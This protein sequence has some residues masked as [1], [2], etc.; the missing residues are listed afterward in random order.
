ML[1][2]PV[3]Q[4]AN[5]YLS[6]I[7]KEL[8]N[9]LEKYFQTG[10]VLHL[11]K[12]GDFLMEH[13][14]DELAND[15]LHHY[16]VATGQRPQEPA[17]LERDLRLVRLSAIL[18]EMVRLA[19]NRGMGGGGGFEPNRKVDPFAHLHPEDR[20]AAR[21]EESRQFAESYSPPE[22]THR[23]KTDEEL[24]QDYQEGLEQE[25]R[26]QEGKKDLITQAPNA[27]P[28]IP[29]KDMKKFSKTVEAVRSK[30]LPGS[31]TVLPMNSESSAAK[32]SPTNFD[33]R[34]QVS[35]YVYLR[36]PDFGLYGIGKVEHNPDGSAKLI[37]PNNNEELQKRSQEAYLNGRGLG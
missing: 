32:V 10:D 37:I 21:K 1:S 22:R 6:V 14:Y 34:G 19:N 2:E 27:I 33:A 16:R 28:T 7:G 5:P 8:G 3:R 36:H 23:N 15:I 30:S 29:I 17:R 13:G 4:Y 25:R 11:G 24:E 20:E 31:D 35:P 12:T 26:H 18:G 9:M